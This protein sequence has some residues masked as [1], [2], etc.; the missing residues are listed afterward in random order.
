ML[1]PDPYNAVYVQPSRRPA[2]G[3][4]GDNPNR[5]YK[6]TQLQVILKPAPEDVVELYMQSLEAIGID[7]TKHDFKLEEDNWESPTLGA[8]G[9]GW[10]VMLDGL[11]ITQFTYFQQCGGLDL[12]LVPAELTYGLERLTAFIQNVDSVYDIRWNDRWSYRDIRFADERQYSVY[13]FEVADVDMVWNEFALHEGECRRL[14]DLFAGLEDATEI[15]RFPLLGRPRPGA[16]VLAPVQHPRRPRGDQRHRARRCH[17]ARSQ[18]GRR[19][20]PSLDAAAARQPP[21]GRRMSE[22]LLEV[23]TE[24]I[25]DWMIVGALADLEKRFLTALADADLAEGV[26]LPDRRHSA[27]PHP[28]GRT[29]LATAQIDKNEHISGPPKSVAFDSDGK[30]TKAAEG[31]SKRAGV[32]LDQIHASV[33]TASCSSSARSKAVRPSTSS[34]RRLPERHRRGLLPQDDVLD[35]RAPA[36]LHPTDSLA[37]R[38]ARRARSFHS[39]SPASRAVLRRTVIAVFGKAE[40]RGDQRLR[41]RG[42]A[43]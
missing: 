31:F 37:R 15:A 24:E 11:E 39:R 34:P 17:P 28:R 21:G 41:L 4:Y 43:R 36:A 40:R 13:N 7:L 20:R 29:G 5:L 10:Q 2:D 27:P 32:S 16:Q 25:P 19:R 14:I 30:P 6:H 1:G 33:T 35:P 42:Q 22:F 26:S 3:R 12:D 38:A 18:L 23:G 9:V 8:W